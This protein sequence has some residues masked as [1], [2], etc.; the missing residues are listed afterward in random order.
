[1]SLG[2]VRIADVIVP[3]IFNP[4]VQVI[5]QEKSNL[6]KS[7]AVIMDSVLSANLS[8][9]GST[10]N[11]PSFKDL[12]NDIENTSSDDPTVISSPNKISS[13]TETQ[14]RLSRNN[15]WAAM[16]LTSDLISADPMAAI[17]NRLGDY[18]ARRLQSLFVATV[19]GVFLDNAA[20]PTGTDTH[21]INDL[22]FDASGVAFVNGV[23][24]FTAES[25]VD[26]TTT[27]G[28]SMND[29]TMIM[30]HSIVYGRMIKNDLIDF[31]PDS[32]GTTKIPT[33]LGRQV[34]VDDG[35]PFSGGV[36]ESWLFGAGAVRLGMGSPMVPTETY[37]LPQAGNGSGQ[38]TLHN[39]VE[40][41]IHPAGHAYLPTYTTG[42][43]TNTTLALASSWSRVFPERKQIKIA[44]LKT[45][46]F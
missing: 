8:G 29:L 1:M 10:F 9:A 36:F 24:N 19:K 28:D 26:T 14:V 2:T 27:I 13:L 4:Y 34:I 41:C 17:G 43:P 7:G 5:T 31:I 25:F 18:W 15:S 16:D 37:R 42:G 39:R 20:A 33:F 21:I 32:T 12:D 3:A 40:W 44:R 23:T 11:V 38:E 6:I 35:M 30:V 22:T 45:R 46:E